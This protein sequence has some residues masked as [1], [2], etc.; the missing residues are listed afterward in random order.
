MNNFEII[1]G[2]LA[3]ILE[4]TDCFLVKTHNLPGNVYHFFIDADTSFDLKK[5]VSTTRQLRKKIE[6]AGLFPEGDFSMEI[7]SPGLD[8][9]LSSHRQYLKNIGRLLR[10]SF[11]DAE[12][13]PLEGRLKEVSETEI[14]L[15][16]TDKKKKTSTS[17]TIEFIQIKQAIIQIEF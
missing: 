10:V 3:E 4:D 16:T 17:H 13:K 12:Q 2:Y 11:T 1:K 6:E 7:S 15:E 5:S 8:E 14:V 9:P